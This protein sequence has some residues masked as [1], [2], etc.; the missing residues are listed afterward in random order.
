MRAPDV[1]V[2]IISIIGAALLCPACAA[3]DEGPQGVVIG[4]TSVAIDTRLSVTRTGEAA[5]GDYITDVILAD[6][7]AMGKPADAMVLNAGAIRG[8]TFDPTTHAPI[9]P[10]SEVGQLYPPG[11]LTDQQI[12][13]WYPFQDDTG[14]VTLSG[15]ALKSGLER[16]ASLLPPDI[17]QEEGGAFLQVSGMRYTID[18]SGTPQVLTAAGDAVATEGTRVVRLEVA[19]KVFYDVAAGVDLLAA[20]SARVVMNTFILGGDDGHIAFKSGTDVEVVPFSAFDLEQ[21]LVADVKAHSPI[22]P[23]KDGRITVIGGCDRA[24]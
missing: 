19:G 11:P 5:I 3:D 13:G 23:A 1:V 21:A 9:T 20:S 15:T 10:S 8:G 4:S 22:A 18:C 17:R 16:A 12:I 24:Q 14:L 6:V 7:R 2:S